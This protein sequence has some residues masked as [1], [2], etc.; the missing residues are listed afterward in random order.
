MGPRQTLM[1][2]CNVVRDAYH[3]DAECRRS[4]TISTNQPKL[5][6]DHV[7]PDNHFSILSVGQSTQ[8]PSTVLPQLSQDEIST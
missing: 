2:L 3:H 4:S 7:R 8:L 5:Q 6:K 1:R